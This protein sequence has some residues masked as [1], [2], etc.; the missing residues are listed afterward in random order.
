MLK[1]VLQ[2]LEEKGYRL[3]YSCR[4]K[5]AQVYNKRGNAVIEIKEYKNKNDLLILIYDDDLVLIDDW[6]C[7]IKLFTVDEIVNEIVNYLEA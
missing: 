1:E 6:A 4:F 2:K 7:M 3:W 5:Y